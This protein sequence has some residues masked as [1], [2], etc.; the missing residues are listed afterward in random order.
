MHIRQL[1]SLWLATSAALATVAFSATGAAAADIP[2]VPTTV[3]APIEAEEEQP[4][5]QL[6]I[7]ALYMTR[8]DPDFEPIVSSDG[9]ADTGDIFNA[10]D[11]DFG[12]RLG[13]EGRAAVIM[14]SGFG[15]DFGGFW[16]R[17][18]TA[19]FDSGAFAPQTVLIETT[20]ETT[21]GSA[22]RV[23]A[24]NTT[25]IWGVDGNVLFAVSPMFTLYGGAA[26]I[27]L[28]TR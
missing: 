14:P 10:D 12:W 7:S 21:F 17:P 11:L 28:R 6:S 2:A 3:V 20:P 19:D 13:V 23:E 5:F 26:F 27:S 22:T 24:D 4:I 16:L 1:N 8:G 9:N 25:S 18:F 15:F